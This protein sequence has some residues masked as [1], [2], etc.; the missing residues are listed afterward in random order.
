MDAIG[1]VLR[2]AENGSG[3][4]ILVEG[5]AGSGKTLLLEEAARVA[6]RFR[7]GSSC[8]FAGDDAGSMAPLLAALFG[9][10]SPLLDPTLLA[11]ARFVP[12][13][14][15]DSVDWLEDALA[16][17]A[18]QRPLLV[19]IDDAHCID[20]G[21]AAALRILSG[22]LAKVPIVWM[23]AVR[24][25]ASVLGQFDHFAELHSLG[26]EHLR[27]PPLED[28]AVAQLISDVV[29]A[30]PSP[31]L[32]EL[33]AFAGG[34]PSLILE[35]VDGAVNESL[36]HI[37]AGRAELLDLRVPRRVRDLTNSRLAGIS[38]FGHRA[39]AVAAELGPTF[40]FDHLATM[41]DVP[42]AALLAPVE[43][44]V[45]A[46]V[47]ADEG[48][49]FAFH[50][51]L[52]REAASGI[53]SPTV[54]HALRRQAIDVLLM[55]GMSPIEPARRLAACAEVGDRVAVST[56]IAAAR[57]VSTSNPEV[58]ADLSRL[59]VDL[60]S[61]TDVLRPSLAAEAALLLHAAGRTEEGIAIVEGVLRERRNSEGDA[62]VRL[63]IARMSDV[64]S[65]VRIDAGRQALTVP[66]LGVDLRA[67]HIAQLILNLAESGETDAAKRLMTEADAAVARGGDVWS[68]NVLEL[69]K[70]HLDQLDGDYRGALAR[71]DALELG[72]RRDDRAAMWLADLR[73]AELL[74]AVDEVDAALEL[75]V[76]MR[77]HRQARRPCC[78]GQRVAAGARSVPVAR[79]S[80]RG[81]NGD[82]RRGRGL[83]AG[84]GAGD[85]ERWGD[86]RRS[87]THRDSHR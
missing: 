62:L 64:S 53:L 71:L 12:T 42:P 35:L 75:A 33:A 72:S 66:E 54:R 17:A 28:H 15:I 18:R 56:L 1:R 82:P 11:D 74:L 63:S 43:E 22:R 58:A 5:P 87:D 86:A 73:R 67:K 30:D 50:N 13:E 78:R 29:R 3:S 52:L 79:W 9:S 76:A 84:R 57:A 6:A 61:P 83:R 77:R 36:V 26:G 24:S 85:S 81:R 25:S 16:T 19:T 69:A 60:T 31:G 55:A 4:V 68:S 80:H 70:A 44:L 51:N 7:V 40:S 21:T 41:L 65:A 14:T 37:S 8:A 46:E 20:R 10:G 38:P 34:D 45:R 59:A 23:L 27:L 2:D 49:H 32:L 47:L 48:T 39:A